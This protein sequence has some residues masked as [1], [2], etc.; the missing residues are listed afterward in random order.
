MSARTV[1]I[2]ANAAWNLVNFRSRLIGALIAD[3]YDMI[4][5]AP[6]D[7][8]AEEALGA[9]GCRFHSVPVDSK[10]V[11]P[12]Q[13][14]RTLIAFDRLF[15]DERPLAFL[16][17]TV[18]PNVYGS[19]AATR[20]GVPAINNVSGLGTAFIAKTW[21]TPVVER[22]YRVGLRR[23]RIVFFQ[24]PDDAALFVGRGLV[25]ASQ[26][27]MLPGSGVDLGHFEPAAWRPPDGEIVFLMIARLLRDKGVVE[28]V[29]AARA[30]RER[31]PAMRFRI[32][33]FRGSEN[34]TAIPEDQ[35][36]AWIAK[37]TI[38]Y[39]GAA[40]DVRPHIAAADCVVLPSYREGTSRVLLEAAAMA[41]P[42]VATDVPG[43]REVVDEGVN[44][45]LC[46]VRDADD[47]ARAMDA[48]AAA[49][50]A[51]RAEMGAAGRAKVAREFDE[52]IVIDAY[53]DALAR[54]AGER[55]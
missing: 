53:R 15:R 18:K 30:C 4:G 42:L 2:A 20:R 22:L 31:N 14:L 47:L 19:I 12:R 11:S 49:G 13:D 5:A 43:C 23:S 38:D 54:I 41:R 21:L 3:G 8:Q 36:D 34:R 51:R 10:G 39:L 50:A 48:V 28:F 7:R 25:R 6:P 32:L 35:V 46:H 52:R 26:V 9:I 37:G 33:G 1:V 29:D 55:G 45:H 17:Y 16:G 40:S 24:N 44:G 27:R